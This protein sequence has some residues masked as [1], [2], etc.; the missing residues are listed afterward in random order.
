M[1]LAIEYLEAKIYLLHPNM[2]I[3]DPKIKKIQEFCLENKVKSPYA[4][5]SVIRNDFN[6]LSLIDLVVDIDKKIRLRIQTF[7]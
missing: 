2:K 6:D 4:F 1:G 7:I 3:E 5:G